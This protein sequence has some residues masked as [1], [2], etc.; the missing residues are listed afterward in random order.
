M[1]FI[2]KY[3]DFIVEKLLSKELRTKNL[4][5]HATSFENLISILNDDVLYGTHMYDRGVATSRNKDYLFYMDEDGEMFSGGA[6]TQLILD[7]D[8]IR[9][10]YKVS[11]F[12]WEEFKRHPEPVYHQ[13]EEKI[14]TDKI[15]GIHKYIVGIHL[16]K[17]VDENYLNLIGDKQFKS[18]IEKYNWI[19]FDE[20]WVIKKG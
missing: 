4:L 10:K 8:K 2:T 1:K 19:I 18:L 5:Y 14:L 6:E 15:V 11:P 7:G 12:D 17:N 9:N 13:S 16:N 20:N 3:S